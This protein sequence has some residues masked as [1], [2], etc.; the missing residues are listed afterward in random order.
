[1]TSESSSSRRRILSGMQPSADSL[2][3]GNYLGAL[4]N[5]VRL[6]DEYDAYFFIP[7]LHAITV[8]QDPEDLRKRTRVTAAQYIAGGVDVDKATLFVQSQVPEH[9]Q[10]AW[11]LNCLT[12]FG[13]ASRMTQF[14]DKQQRFG[15]D[16]ASV[17]LFTYPILQVA[18]ILLYQPHGVP[19]GEDQRQH[20]ELSRDLAKRFNTRFGETFVVPE[21]FIQKAAA[22]IY[23]LQNPSA[24]MSKS[25][26]SPAGLINL[27]DEDKVIAKRIK[28]AVTDDGSEIRFDRDA[29]PGVS[30]LLSIYSL[31]S[32]R[33]VETLEKEYEGK[34]YGHLKVDLAEVVTEHIRPIRERALHLLDD[35]AELDRL[36][37]VGAAK[38]RESASVTLADVYNKVGFLPLGSVTA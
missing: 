34:M 23:D 7:D 1:M 4:V 16:S 20:V 33:S 25:A 10:L 17:G 27:L 13:E 26:A 12:G 3:L 2:H 30:N 22:K 9:A 21:V 36:L 31:I 35:P 6:Q 14:K 37:A 32:G 8:P 11:V 19:V 15:S 38:A 28:S 18:D 29:K 24:K 5:W